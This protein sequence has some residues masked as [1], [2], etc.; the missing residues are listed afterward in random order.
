MIRHAVRH[1]LPWFVVHN[2]ACWTCKR[3]YG[4]S[5]QLKKHVDED[6]EDQIR[7]RST[8]GPGT[9]P[10]VWARICGGVVRTR[11]AHVR[12]RTAV[13]FCCIFMKPAH[14]GGAVGTGRMTH[15]LTHRKYDYLKRYVHRVNCVA[16]GEIG[17]D[18]VRARQDK[19]RD[20]QAEVFVQVC[21]LAREFNKPVVIHCRG[22][23]NTGKECL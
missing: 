10:D 18:H 1:H 11:V 2:M 12:Q 7:F 14:E 6:L 13:C 20:Q 19:D 9:T 4:S 15:G 22:T 5:G 3:Q 21:Q 16:V 8:C 17:L 23:A